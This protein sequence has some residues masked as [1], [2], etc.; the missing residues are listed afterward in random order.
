MADKVIEPITYIKSVSK[1]KV[2]IEFTLTYANQQMWMK[3]GLW[4]I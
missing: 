3:F 1:K 2:T 4:K